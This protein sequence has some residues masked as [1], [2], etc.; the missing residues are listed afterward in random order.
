MKRLLFISTAFINILKHNANTLSL[1]GTKYRNNQNY[2][3]FKP[4]IYLL[5]PSYQN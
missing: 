5:D 1:I 3:S 2:C 4:K